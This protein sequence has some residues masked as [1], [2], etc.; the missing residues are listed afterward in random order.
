M[1]R[2]EVSG[3]VRPLYGSLGVKGLKSDKKTVTF[4]E[5]RYTFLIIS[6]SVLLKIKNVSGQ[7]CRENEN[8]HFVLSNIFPKTV[9]FMRK[10]G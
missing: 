5:D 3:A 4:R 1:Q 8:T 7:S 10:C 6:R 2:L 9:P